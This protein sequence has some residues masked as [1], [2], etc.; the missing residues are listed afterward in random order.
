M[1]KPKIPNNPARAYMLGKLHGTQE[2]MGNVAMVLC[3]KF[4]WHI[5]EK[6]DDEHDA[7]SIQRLYN[8]L[9]ELAEEINSGRI[10]HKD[11]ADVLA[12]EHHAIFDD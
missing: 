6:T 2:N 1:K 8:C 3:D 7:Q 5:E 12:E 9:V 4:G 11:I 10:K